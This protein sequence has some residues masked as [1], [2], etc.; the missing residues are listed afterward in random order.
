MPDKIWLKDIEPLQEGKK[1]IVFKV[2]GDDGVAKVIKL[3]E[4]HPSRAIVGT[5]LLMQ[6]GIETAAILPIKDQGIAK[7]Q[8]EVK[9]LIDEKLATGQDATA[10][11]SLWKA[12]DQAANVRGTKFNNVVQMDFVTGIDLEK[13]VLKP[14]FKQLLTNPDFQKQLG[15]VMAADAFTGNDDRFAARVKQGKDASAPLEGWYNK[16]NLIIEGEGKNV[17]LKAIDNDFRPGANVTERSAYG[18]TTHGAQWGSVAAA[19]AQHFKREIFAIVERMEKEANM[20]L[21]PQE[22]KRLHHHGGRGSKRDDGS[23]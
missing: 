6:A 2:T 17:K 20:Q 11:Q 21:S 15:Q 16:N 5:A 8:E 4:E 23:P 1:G 13:A 19:N 18:G 9:A 10:A 3:Q 12:L 14:D 7:M 22:L